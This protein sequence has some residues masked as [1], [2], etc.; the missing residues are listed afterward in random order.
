M[1]TLKNIKSQIGLNLKGTFADVS[2][3]LAQSKEKLESKGDSRFEQNTKK[4]M[5]DRINNSEELLFND[6]QSKNGNQTGEEFKD[7]GR[8]NSNGNYIEE[9]GHAQYVYGVPYTS[10]ANAITQPIRGINN[11]TNP[12]PNGYFAGAKEG[13]SSFNQDM[14]QLKMAELKNDYN[15]FKRRGDV[16]KYVHGGQHN[17]LTGDPQYDYAS[18]YI[19]PNASKIDE[20]GYGERDLAR[21]QRKDIRNEKFQNF[22]NS[23][24][25]SL[26]TDNLTNAANFVSPILGNIIDRQAIKRLKTDINPS[27][28][29]AQ[30]FVF[31]DTTSA[32]ERKNAEASRQMLNNINAGSTQTQ[33]A[34][35]A[36][37]LANRLRADNDVNISELQRKDQYLG[38]YRD[39]EF[40]RNAINSQTINSVNEDNLNRRNNIVVQRQAANNALQ[41]G[42]VNAI[43]AY[44]INKNEKT[45]MGLTTLL[46]RD[47]A[48]YDRIKND[49]PKLFK[50]LFG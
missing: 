16:P 45:K 30:P 31:N 19:D 5:L 28:I 44:N 6:Q 27:L 22:N 48:M 17:G 25:S 37:L 36:A 8:L 26:T 23:V 20:I 24:S 14:N 38:H 43:Q 41:S 3:K 29:E 49:N 33:V 47:P 39:T 4:I 2:K 1:N 7:G 15:S 42:I 12:V 32:R 18:N 34:A 9:D 50:E 21:Q 35:K 10:R 46:L 11:V 13:D 40:R